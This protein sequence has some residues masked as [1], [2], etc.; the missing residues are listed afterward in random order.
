MLIAIDLDEVLAEFIESFIEFHNAVYGTKLKRNQIK[1][2]GLWE[3]L[4]CSREEGINKVIEFHKTRYFKNIKPVEGAIEGV[5]KLGRKNEL[6]VITSRQEDIYEDTKEWVSKYFPQSFSTIYFTSS[7]FTKKSFNKENSL[8]KSR[9][10]S[11]LNVGLL[12]EDSLDEATACSS[13]K[14]KVL[15]FDCPWNHSKKL[16]AGITR[17]HSWKEIT[18]K[19]L[20]K[21]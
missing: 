8:I 20:G 6:I 21:N 10:C 16:P 7:Y 1:S 11:E 4:G 12:I 19:I 18:R 9:L 5:K 2:Y 14:T 17:A 13:E 15:L 3:A